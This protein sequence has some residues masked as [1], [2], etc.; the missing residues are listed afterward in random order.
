MKRKDI[1]KL[2]DSVVPFIMHQC[3]VSYQM[4][5]GQEYNIKPTRHQLQSLR[6]ATQFIGKMKR[7]TSKKMHDNW[8]KYKMN[9]GWKY[10]FK[11]DVNKKTH[12]DLVPW[13]QLTI[14]EQNK[15]AMCLAS[16]RFAKEL[17]L[18]IRRNYIRDVK[19]LVKLEEVE[20]LS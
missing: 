17:A 6:N 5:A 15:D 19:K 11:K 2:V 12:P 1:D 8:C 18:V 10:G 16:Y 9:N 13:D 3:W 20:T 14:V 4:G 7:P